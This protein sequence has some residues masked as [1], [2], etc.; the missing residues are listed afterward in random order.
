MTLPKTDDVRKA[1]DQVRT[2]LLAALGAGDLATK[3]VVDLVAKAR[4][5]AT[6][7]GEAVK[8]A[9]EDLP[10]DLT[11]LRDRLDPSE[12]RKRVDEYTDAALK[13]YRKLADDGESTL[14][15]LRTRPQ[16]KKAIEQFEKAIG[17]AQTRAEGVAGEARELAEDVLAKVT[18]KTRSV[19]E[20]TARAAQNV[21]DE[22]AEKIEE[23]GDEVAHEVRSTT[24]RVANKTAPK[25]TTPAAT[26]K[27]ST[28]AKTTK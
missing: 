13:F 8:G 27:P 6:T 16:V 1:A 12:L 5:R 14:D 11:Q 9:V 25:R 28:T 21:A 2:P 7:R 20:K 19:G 24:R 3:A 4:E 18:R 26:G 15:K 23:V 17:T 10:T 22:A